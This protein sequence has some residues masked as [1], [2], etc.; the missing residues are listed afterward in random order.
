MDSQLLLSLAD[1]NPA[2]CAFVPRALDAGVR[3]HL[4]LLGYLGV[5]TGCFSAVAQPAN[6]DKGK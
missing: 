2:S 3:E 5:P 1:E 6:D 4:G